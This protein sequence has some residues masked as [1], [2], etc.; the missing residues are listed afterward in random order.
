MKK[1]TSLL[2]GL[3][4][5]SLLAGCGK[6]PS[7]SS[8]PISDEEMVA[9]AIDNPAI[10]I[11]KQTG[12]GL[13]YG[14]TYELE[15]ALE[16]SL[17]LTTKI[18][19]R[20]FDVAIQWVPNS[21]SAF[22]FGAEDE[23]FHIEAKPKYPEIGEARKGV[24]LT[25]TAVRGEAKS[26]AVQFTF[27]LIAPEKK[28]E[29]SDLSTIAITAESKERLWVEG[30]VTRIMF[31]WDIAFIQAYGFAIGLYKIGT[32]GKQITLKDG[33]KRDLQVGDYV[34][35]IGQYSPYNGLKEIG[36]VESMEEVD[37]PAGFEVGAVRVLNEENFIDDTTISDYDGTLVS[38]KGLK[39]ERLTAANGSTITALPV[40]SG[41][42][43]H[44]NIVAKLGETEV[45]ISISYHIGTDMQTQLGNKFN[46]M[47]VGTTFDYD[48][49]LGWNNG[50]QLMLLTI[51]DLT[52]AA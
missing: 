18:Q 20:G 48:G 28:F 44:A 5:V 45:V 50:P 15:G 32:S 31:D 23:S 40:G 13:L 21:G 8:Q 22:E 27:T 3:V 43:N 30:E 25:A 17:L 29:K 26:Q 34:K 52:F 4:S 37:R 35:A 1:V 6:T 10:L 7:V 33:T 38:V 41:S 12:A 49:I 2:I 42:A 16:T 19:V 36:F 51:A 9:Q 14:Q 46:T 24:A 11:N 47:A 39:F